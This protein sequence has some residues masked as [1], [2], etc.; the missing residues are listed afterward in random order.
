MTTV[1]VSADGDR[2]DP[3]NNFPLLLLALDHAPCA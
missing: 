3:F 1:P 2:S